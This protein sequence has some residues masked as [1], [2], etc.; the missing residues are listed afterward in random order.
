MQKVE[1]TLTTLEKPFITQKRLVLA[2]DDVDKYDI[3]TLFEE[4]VNFGWIVTKIEC[5]ENIRVYKVE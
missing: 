5:V 4:S 3:Y 1:V 2:D